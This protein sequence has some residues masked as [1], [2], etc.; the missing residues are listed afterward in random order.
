MARALAKR[1]LCNEVCLREVS[2][3]LGLPLNTVRK[4]ISSQFEYVKTVMESGT[5]DSVR[6]GYLGVFKS[7]PKEVQ[8]IN[9]L[10]GL[11]EEQ[12][13]EFKKAVRTGKIKFNLW[14]KDA[15][16]IKQAEAIDSNNDA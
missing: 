4:M 10:K 3:E 15:N 5:F 1:T 13:R 7:K 6:L 2:E 14:E 16:R 12:A 11:S 8:M 9:H